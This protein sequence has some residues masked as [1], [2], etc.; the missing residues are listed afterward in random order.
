V[1]HYNALYFSLLS[2]TCIEIHTAEPFVPASISFEAEIAI[3][4]LKKYKRPG[5]IPILAELT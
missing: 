5:S 4:K 3:A 1:K 2:Y